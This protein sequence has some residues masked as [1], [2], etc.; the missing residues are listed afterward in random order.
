M[1]NW[2]ANPSVGQNWASP[3]Q[4][5]GNISTSKVQARAS[6]RKPAGKPTARMPTPAIAYPQK[7]A[8][9]SSGLIRKLG[10]V[11]RL[12]GTL[13]GQQKNAVREL[14]GLLGEK[15]F[16][17][18]DRTLNYGDRKAIKTSLLTD[19]AGL[20]RVATKRLQRHGK[21]L[22]ASLVEKAFSKQPGLIGGMVKNR[23]LGSA[24]GDIENR[25]NGLLKKGNVDSKTSSYYDDQPRDISFKDAARFQKAFN[26]FR[27]MQRQTEK[28]LG[29]KM[30]YP[31]GISQNFMEHVLSNRPGFPPDVSFREND[32]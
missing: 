28:N 2:L 9:V 16:G 17:G 3:I 4:Q 11:S 25:L 18:R 1:T 5:Q 23:V 30:V 21:N 13:N 7:A 24:E 29:V 26:V 12:F 8:G 14:H 20:G 32:K 22:R 10:G 27:S 6:A 31:K 15:K 19:E